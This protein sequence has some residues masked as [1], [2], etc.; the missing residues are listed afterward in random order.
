LEGLK[1]QAVSQGFVTTIMGRR[2]YFNF[3][4]DSLQKLKG[5]EIETIN[6]DQLKYS[7]GDAQ[8]LRA[9]A[10]APIQGSSADIIKIAMVKLGKILQNYQTKLLLQVHDELVFEVP[11]EEWEEIETII[12]DTMENAINLTVPLLVDIN[13]G[14]NWMETK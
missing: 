10:N 3:E 2:R 14:K 4:S 1:K 13:A 11:L 5:T 6:L 7:F 12:K 9:A 8:L